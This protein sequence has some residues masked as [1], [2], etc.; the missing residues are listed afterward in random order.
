MRE[1]KGKILLVEDSADPREVLQ[2]L[3]HL[4]GFEVL[5]AAD[6]DEGLK[7][8]ARERPDLILTDLHCPSSTASN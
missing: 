8:A 4:H 3:L 7:L 2:V 5:A 6:G 1:V